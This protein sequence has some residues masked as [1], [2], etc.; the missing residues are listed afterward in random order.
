MTSTAPYFDYRVQ[1]A[2]LDANNHLANA[3]FLNYATEARFDYF[4]SA[5]I[6]QA[7]FARLGI[8]PV[9]LSDQI[10]YAK[11]LR[12]RDPLRVSILQGGIN[13]RKTRFVMV[14]RFEQ[15]E[16]GQLCAELRSMYVWFSRSARKS[17]PPT[18]ALLAAIEALPRDDNF[19]AL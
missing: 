11:E 17:V 4:A 8:G 2:D 18:E 6:D 5:G 3:S 14:N 12:H 10:T 19:E 7:E 9:V 16:T 13:A 15:P 1:W